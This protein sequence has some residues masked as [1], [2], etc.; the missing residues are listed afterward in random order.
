MLYLILGRTD[1]LIF[2]AEGLSVHGY[3]IIWF[4]SLFQSLLKDLF[5]NTYNL[6]LS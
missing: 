2:I 5:I 3:V 4:N 6:V 1:T